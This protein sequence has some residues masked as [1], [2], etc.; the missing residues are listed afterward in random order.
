MFKDGEVRELRGR[1]HLTWWQQQ[2]AA[3]RR[4]QIPAC[5]Y[6]EQIDVTTSNF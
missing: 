4:K 5:I 1:I 2:M 3:I 6:L